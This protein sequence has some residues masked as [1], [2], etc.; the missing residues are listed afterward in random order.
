[1]ELLRN[2]KGSEAC[3][4][5]LDS[6]SF[7]PRLIFTFLNPVSYIDAVSHKELFGEFDGIFVDGSILVWFIRLFYGVRIK[8]CSFDMTSLAPKL[9]DYAIEN[10]KSIAI[11]A[12]KQNELERAVEILKSRF[13]GLNV[14]YSRNG[15]FSSEEERRSV[16]REVVD[17]KPDFLI[18]GMGVV[19][20][21]QFLVEAKRAGFQGVGF[22]CG[23]FIHQTSKN[24]VDYYPH[25]I[26]KYNLRFLYRFIKEK[27]TRKRYFK[28][29]F[30]FPF[31]F[32]KERFFQ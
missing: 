20:Q 1:M 27:H 13:T 32:L 16:I 3:G 18:C 6:I 24:E 17:N 23:G 31:L 10:N 19:K 28:A 15:Y 5:V 4:S 12:S 8:R 21:E 7:S 2:I 25:W 11:V 29:T 22:T 30:V 9:F 14:I 26:D